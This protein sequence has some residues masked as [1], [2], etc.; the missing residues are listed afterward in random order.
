MKSFVAMLIVFAGM[1]ILLSRAA[2]VES[3]NSLSSEIADDVH[4]LMHLE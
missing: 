2:F 4:Y 3:P 1:L